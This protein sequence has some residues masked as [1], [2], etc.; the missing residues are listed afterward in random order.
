MS[1]LARTHRVDLNSMLSLV[2]AEERDEAWQ[3]ITALFGLGQLTEAFNTAVQLF[4]FAGSEL[5]R[6]R[7]E[8]NASIAEFGDVLT[9]FGKRRALF[10]SHGNTWLPEMALSRF[11]TSERSSRT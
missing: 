2:P 1:D 3:L 10:F 5:A 7:N 6:A 8:R 9:A 4:N 11:I